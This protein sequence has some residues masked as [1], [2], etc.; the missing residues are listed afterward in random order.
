[1]TGDGRWKLHLPHNYR[2]LGGKSGGQDG[3]PAK[4]ESHKLEQPELYDLDHDLAETSNIADRHPNIVQRL[5]GFA[6]VPVPISA[7]RLP[8]ARGLAFASQAM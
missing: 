7:T 1:V 3:V 8:N 6:S 5:E 2:T 4:Y